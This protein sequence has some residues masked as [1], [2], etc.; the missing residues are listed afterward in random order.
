[1]IIIIIIIIVIVALYQYILIL[2]PWYI[3]NS[4]TENSLN[5]QHIAELAAVLSKGI[6]HPQ[7]LNPACIITF[8]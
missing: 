8:M 6:L 3:Y 2:H 7:S 5:S 4:F 1:M